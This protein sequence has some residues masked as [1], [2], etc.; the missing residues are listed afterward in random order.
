MPMASLDG[1]LRLSY[2]ERGPASSQAV[3][4]LPGP[5]DAWPSYE[6]ILGSMPEDLRVVAVSLRG[7]GQSSKPP[8][9]YTVEDLAS[10]VVPFLDALDIGR[11][12]LVGHSGSCLVARRVALDEPDRVGGL[13][14]EASP[15]TLRGHERLERFVAELPDPIDRDF[16]RTFV[17]DT[18][19]DALDPDLV[20]MFV[21]DVLAVPH[22]A[23]RE[24]FTSLLDH[25]D[26]AALAHVS[27][28]VTLV[29][30]DDDP[31]V[32]RA[33]QDELLHLLPDA[34]LLVYA[35][36]GHTPRWEQPDR[37]AADLSSFVRRVLRP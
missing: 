17:A 23:W 22:A 12:V 6:P 35:H 20:E 2:C 34:Q 19:S 36:V 16:A 26:T 21:D 14:L 1:G 4:L 9:R 24:M 3:V 31:L 29:W 28:P 10:D 32:P 8:S 5:T 7:H 33:M 27:A 13:L 11:A 18:S 37:F 30:G 15:T 25:D